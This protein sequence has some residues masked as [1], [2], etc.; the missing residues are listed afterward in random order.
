MCTANGL[1][2]SLLLRITNRTLGD[3][4][5][6]HW[7]A[8]SCWAAWVTETGVANTS[9]SP[10]QLLALP[11]EVPPVYVRHTLLGKVCTQWGTAWDGQALGPRSTVG[12]DDPTGP[13]SLVTGSTDQWRT[14]SDTC[15]MSFP[16]SINLSIM[17]CVKLLPQNVVTDTG[18]GEER[19]E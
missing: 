13:L 15:L 5:W 1:W 11:V 9:W 17:L 18:R 16:Y 4:R 2:F 12:A 3:T 7:L 8:P 6:N 10:P 14:V 19:E